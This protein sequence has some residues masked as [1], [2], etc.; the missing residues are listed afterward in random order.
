MILPD[1]NVLVHAF[2][3]SAQQHAVYARWLNG[4]RQEGEELL[5][6]DSVLTGF[7]RMVTHPG[8]PLPSVPIDRAL[9]FISLLRTDPS[10]RGIDDEGAV[11]AT[12]GRMAADDK[13]IKGNVVPDAYLAAVA[14]SHKARIATRDRG[15]ARFPGLHWFD[16]AAA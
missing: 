14:I 12:F 3:E 8:I 4:V 5:L 11:W 1:V 6:P 10:S 9:R 16:P 7:L 15:F 2:R 13:G